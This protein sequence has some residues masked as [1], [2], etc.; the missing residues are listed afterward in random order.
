KIIYEVDDDTS[1]NI[2][3]RRIYVSG[4]SGSGGIVI[5]EIMYDPLT[6]L[7]EWI[8]FY[9]ASGQQI[10]LKKW[11]FKESAA[12]ITLSTQDLFLNPGDYLILAH[13][14][15]IFESYDLL[16]NP[17]P[18]QIVKFSNGIS[19]NNSGENISLTDSLNN[20]IDAV[21]YNP[22]WN[23]PE[24]PDTKGI[25]LER[26][27]PSFGS[28]DKNN[29]N[30]CADIAGGTP[31]LQNSIFL[32]N[33]SHAS[34]VTISPNPFSPD[35]DGFEDFALI[36][37]KLTFPFAQMRVKVFDIK[38]RLVRTLANNQFTGNEGS[39]IFNGYGD[40]NQRLRI[41]IYILL[42]EAVDD[43]GGTVDNVKAPI[44]VAARL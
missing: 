24:L 20:V 4:E 15:S 13:D 7:S 28:N 29:W 22:N 12:G 43:R 19:L 37:Y 2:S 23:N 40:D 44:V 32:K 36:K 33:L 25:S 16:K 10:N 21:S 27:N 26:I 34:A 3:V 30:S 8:E 42:I 9:N 18:N 1:N 41:G 38:G 35:G 6:N 17:N 14:S 11:K 5:N 31:G 39:I